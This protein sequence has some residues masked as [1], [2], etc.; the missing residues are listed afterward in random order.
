MSYNTQRANVRYNRGFNLFKML[1]KGR[2]EVL[3]WKIVVENAKKVRLSY[4]WDVVL[5]KK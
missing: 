1:K 5:F 3:L 4:G 2:S